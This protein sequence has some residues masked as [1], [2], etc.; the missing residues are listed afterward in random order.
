MLLILSIVKQHFRHLCHSLATILINT[1]RQAT[2]LYMGGET[3]YSQEGTT[4]GDPLDMPIY[5]IAILPL[6]RQ[7][8]KAVKQVWY[9][10]DATATGRTNLRDW[11]DKLVTNGPAYGY[12]VNASKTWVIVKESHLSATTSAFENTQVR[13]TTEGKPHLG[14]ALSTQAYIDHYVSHKVQQWSNEIKQLSSIAHTQLHAAYAALTHGLA[15][16]W[17]Y[18]ARTIPNISQPLED[19][20]RTDLIPALTWRAPPS[21]NEWDLLAVP[22]RLDW[23]GESSETFRLRIHSFKIYH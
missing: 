11:W 22:S 10:D 4:R 1:Y 2:D 5:A 13:I 20:V 12:H 14:A 3:L 7:V 9:A 18:I 23:C 15:S 8:S 21:D 16:K 17:Y 6:I 19:V